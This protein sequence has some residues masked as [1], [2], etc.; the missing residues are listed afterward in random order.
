MGREMENKRCFFE[1]ISFSLRVPHR[2]GCAGV[3]DLFPIGS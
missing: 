1:R 3:F 2:H